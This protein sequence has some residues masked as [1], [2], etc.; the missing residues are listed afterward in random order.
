[1]RNYLIPNLIYFELTVNIYQ[2]CLWFH[3][4]KQTKEKESKPK[5]KEHVDRIC[6]GLPMQEMTKTLLCSFPSPDQNVM[7]GFDSFID[8]CI[9]FSGSLTLCSV[10]L[11]P[12]SLQCTLHLFLEVHVTS[13]FLNGLDCLPHVS[14]TL[15]LIL[16]QNISSI[17]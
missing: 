4:R 10:C 3:S 16:I 6:V 14:C 5:K 11:F 15:H 1:M 13:F 9:F 7:S 12:L 2:F 8:T 17:A